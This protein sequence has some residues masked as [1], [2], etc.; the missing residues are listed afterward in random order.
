MQ[1]ITSFIKIIILTS[2]IC[3]CGKV[4]E[5]APSLNSINEHPDTWRVEHRAA[6]IDN[7]NQCR[8]CHG[9]DLMGGITKIDC[10]NQAGLGECH[11]AGHGPRTVIHPIPFSDPVLHGAMAKV[12]LTVCQDCHGTRGGAGS[13]PRFNIVY[14]SLPQG[15]ET[16]GCHAPQMAHPKPWKTHAS[17]GNQAN[18]CALCHGANFEG[19]VITAAPS[20]KSCH[21]LLPDGV[22]PFAGQ[23]ISCHGNPP[24]GTVTPNIAGS[25]AAH[26]G[27]T[28][29]SGNCSACH[30]GGG[31]G[32]ANHA[33]SL[34]V[35]FAPEFGQNPSFNGSTCSNVSC[36]GG[37][38]TPVW[39]VS[40]DV[41]ANC[42]KCHKSATTYPGYHSGEHTIHLLKGL[43]CTD[44]HDM[45]NQAVHFANV[46]T[47]VFETSPE[48]TLRTYLNYNKSS[49]SCM[50]SSPT[51][52]GVQFTGCHGGSQAWQ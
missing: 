17:S 11:A 20:C 27:L 6:Y 43:L 46:V 9:T 16:S 15:C 34:T 21:K 4:N 22:V 25:H 10:F 7:S 30:T 35:G 8:E 44:C 23:C 50:V 33:V 42:T 32:A 36:H 51:P 41:T 1:I 5:Q 29:M 40:L 2:L 24:N 39:G 3:S 45:N 19:S 26:L 28:G 47:P 48:S 52:A 13:D 18:A 12:D 37:Q 14:G 31:A 38:A 49:Q